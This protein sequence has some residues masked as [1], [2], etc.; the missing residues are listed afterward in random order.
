M[1]SSF[2]NVYHRQIKLASLNSEASANSTD[3]DIY[4]EIEYSPSESLSA[5]VGM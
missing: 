3:L 5:H 4:T 1:A 2:L